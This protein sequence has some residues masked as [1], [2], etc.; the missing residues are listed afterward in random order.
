MEP[1][2][3]RIADNYLGLRQYEVVIGDTVLG[4]IEGYHPTFER[5]RPGARIVDRR[6][7]S[8]KVYWVAEYPG[9]RNKY[10]F[11][12]ETRKRAVDSILWQAREKGLI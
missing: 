7:K 6:W 3:R 12:Y 8:K 11:P 1:D 9:V 10:R 5:S 2:L 4:R